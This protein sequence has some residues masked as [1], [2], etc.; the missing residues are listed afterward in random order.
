[1]II[2]KKKMALLGVSLESRNMGVQALGHGA[3]K[4]IREIFPDSTVQIIDYGYVRNLYS[5]WTK[6][7][8]VSVELVNLRFSKKL[9]L[10][11]N[12]AF[13]LVLSLIYRFSPKIIKN[14][15]KSSNRWL[16]EICEAELCLALS[17]GD[18]FSDIYG[19]RRL[20]YV[21][22]PQVIALICRTP[23]V[24]LPQTIGPFKKYFSKGLAQFI[25]R[26]SSWIFARDQK[27]FEVAS[28]LC[29]NK[30]QKGKIEFC[31]DLGFVMDAK[32]PAKLPE[33]F[34]GHNKI[35]NNV[36]GLN[37]SGLL[38]I[39]GYTRDN[40]FD[41]KIDYSKF[42]VRLIDHIIVDLGMK[43][44]LIPHVMGREDHAESDWIACNGIF[45]KIEDRYPGMIGF[46]RE[47]YD[48]NEIKYIIGECQFF[49]GSRMH[50]CIAALSQCTT[51]VAISYSRKFAG[52]YEK[53]G[54]GD[55][56]ADPREKNEEEIVRQIDSIFENKEIFEMRLKRVVPGIKKLIFEKMVGLR[57]FIS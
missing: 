30:S 51:A 14:R 5:V 19:V 39:G 8:T 53:L 36:I 35:W 54:C 11:N 40:A 2:Y 16:R 13:L 15:I 9:F 29:S 48:Q 33:I 1:M 38:S 44:L 27:S 10:K 56:V 3:I 21:C 7:S 32:E 37:V 6:N 20:V 26:N 22:F 42:I 52:V 47:D 25:I 55:L 45:S 57:K 43:V 50:S 12:V 4:T 46:A 28:G 49:I 41:L 24:Q 18:S 31:Y 34:N 23:L 17:G